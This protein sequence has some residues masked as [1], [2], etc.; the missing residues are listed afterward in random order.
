MA[1]G[2]DATTNT[3]KSVYI[4]VKK[5]K[6]LKQLAILFTPLKVMTCT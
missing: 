5:K 3:F 4:I 2:T 1:L 6:V